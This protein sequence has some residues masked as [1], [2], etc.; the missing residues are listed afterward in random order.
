MTLRNE[1]SE[2]VKAVGMLIIYAYSIGY[3]LTFGDTYPGKFKHKENSFHSKGLAIDLNA[4]KDGI[5]LTE[6]KDYLALG[7][8][9]KQLGG[10]WGGFFS[11]V[12]DANHFSWGEV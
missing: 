2:F 12:K 4:F 8:Y 9:W 6:W 7:V 11:N 3:E 1:Q 10:T 5:Y